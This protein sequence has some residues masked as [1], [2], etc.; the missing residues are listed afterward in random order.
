MA[1]GEEGKSGVSLE[2]GKSTMSLS[3]GAAYLGIGRNAIYAHVAAGRIAVVSYPERKNKLVTKAALD[4]F[5][6]SCTGTLAGT[7]DES[8][9]AQ[10]RETSGQ[11]KV[12]LRLTKGRE[13]QIDEVFARK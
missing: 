1:E 9:S 5:R 3:K 4:A 8:D 12:S 2:A 7:N 11:F 13:A 10:V 6:D